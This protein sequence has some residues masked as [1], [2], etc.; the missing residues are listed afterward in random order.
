M[1]KILPKKKNK[2]T[3]VAGCYFLFDLLDAAKYSETENL[4]KIL[5]LSN[6]DSSYCQHDKYIFFYCTFSF[7]KQVI[8]ILNQSDNINI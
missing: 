3:G 8:Y 5:M 2:G 1:G 6:L 7:F 4:Y